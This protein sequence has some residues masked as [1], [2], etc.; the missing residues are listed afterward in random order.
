MSGKKSIRIKAIPNLHLEILHLSK[1]PSHL[2]DSSDNIE[3]LDSN[4]S[5]PPYLKRHFKANTST[6]F[7]SEMSQLIV[8][9]RR[10]FYGNEITKQKKKQ[11]V[12]FID[13]TKH[14]KLAEIIEVKSLKNALEF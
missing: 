6:T 4:S 2:S 14:H 9:S 11:R 7:Q 10:D 5:V 3:T 8:K 12:T 1:I 13:K